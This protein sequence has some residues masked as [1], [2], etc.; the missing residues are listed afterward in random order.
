M[1]YID[2][3]SCAVS[4]YIMKRAHGAWPLGIVYA[5][6][7]A[8]RGGA[9]WCVWR[10]GVGAGGSV[11]VVRVRVWCVCGVCGVCVYV[12]GGVVCVCVCRGGGWGVGGIP[13]SSKSDVSVPLCTINDIHLCIRII[14]SV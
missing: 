10:G 11:G 4:F 1:E 5:K 12:W 6:P 3:D 13:P 8:R 9:E 2:D 7:I 14:A